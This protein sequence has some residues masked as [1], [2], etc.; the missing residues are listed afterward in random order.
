MRL[1]KSFAEFIQIPSQ[2]DVAPEQRVIFCVYDQKH[3][4]VLRH[5]W[6]E[7]EKAV[8]KAE[9]DFDTFDLQSLFGTWLDETRYVEAYFQQPAHLE[10]IRVDWLDFLVQRYERLA[11]PCDANSVMLLTGLGY[12]FGFIRVKQVIERFAPMTPGRLVAFF[13][14]TFENN[15]YRLLNA[16]DGWNYLAIPLP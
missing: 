8:E 11:A 5:Y 2:L 13:P 14:G 16:Y 6:H 7:F 4:R 3:E 1:V 12:L 9:L 15:N 10:S